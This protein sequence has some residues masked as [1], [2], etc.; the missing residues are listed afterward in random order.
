MCAS[1]SQPRPVE[2]GTKYLLTRRCTHRQFLLRPGNDINQVFRYCLGCASKQYHVKIHAVVVMSNHFHIVATDVDGVLPDFMTLLNGN[3]ARSLNS[4]YQRSENFW[5]PKKYSR[6][7]LPSNEAVLEKMVYTLTNPVAAGLVSSGTEWPGVIS[8]TLRDGPQR[9]TVKKPDFFF[10]KQEDGGELPDEV[11]L[12]IERPSGFDD[13]DDKAFGEALQK[14]VDATEKGHGA[15]L[16]AKGRKFLGAKRVR[17][18]S[19]KDFPKTH[20]PRGNID[21]IVATRNPK[22]R[23]EALAAYRRF[24]GE[25]AVALAAYRAGD[26]DVIFPAGTYWMRK[27]L[28]VKCG[29]H[30]EA[31]P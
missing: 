15:K 20:E 9:I 27:H 21:P 26:H 18:Q 25:Y 1:M 10:R 5:E 16:K 6:P 30:E 14:A 24:L 3:L 12:V 4:F 2:P 29:A 8:D 11:E 28:G 31:P 7:M 19:P 23:V 17:A 22:L 13:L